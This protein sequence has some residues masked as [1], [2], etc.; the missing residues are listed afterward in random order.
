M[1]LWRYSGRSKFYF[2]R[3]RLSQFMWSLLVHWHPRRSSPFQPCTAMRSSIRI[4][5]PQKNW[6]RCWGLQTTF[7]PMK[8]LEPTSDLSG[9]QET[10]PSQIPGNGEY[11]GLRLKSYCCSYCFFPPYSP[12]SFCYRVFLF[13]IQ[14]MLGAMDHSSCCY[15]ATTKCHH[16]RVPPPPPQPQTGVSGVSHLHPFLGYGNF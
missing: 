6:C 13:L 8:L 4:C 12:D 9:T 16:H 5:Q 1:I 14:E 15:I 10:Y 2:Q 11:S 3:D 7:L